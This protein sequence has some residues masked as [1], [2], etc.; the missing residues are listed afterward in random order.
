M[1]EVA[2][3]EDG[4]VISIH[5]NTAERNGKQLDVMCCIVFQVEDGQIIDGRENFFDLYAWD[6]F[7]A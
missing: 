5:R 7:W 3:S 6:E 1:Q 2:S 4:S